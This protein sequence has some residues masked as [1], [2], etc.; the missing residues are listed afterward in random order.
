MTRLA[1]DHM[2]RLQVDLPQKNQRNR[3]GAHPAQYALPPAMPESDA[4]LAERLSNAAR[5]LES[6]RDIRLETAKS[7]SDQATIRQTYDRMRYALY[8][9]VAEQTKDQ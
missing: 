6:E 5:I 8:E 7:S 9:A 3:R 4:P 2:G 1:T